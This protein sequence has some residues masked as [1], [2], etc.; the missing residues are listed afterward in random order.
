MP[1]RSD[2]PPTVHPRRSWRFLL[3]LGTVLAVASLLAAR[4]W[5]LLQPESTELRIAVNPW[6]GY[7]FAFLAEE[8]G[9]FR[10]EGVRVRLL[11]LSSLADA[12]RAFERGQAD[13]FFGTVVELVY[14]QEYSLRKPVPVMAVNVSEGAD[15]ILARPDIGSVADLRGRRVGVENGSLTVYV[16]ARALERH[17]LEWSDIEA[18]H[19]PTI[20][21]AAL[22]ALGKID[23]AVTYPPMSHEIENTGESRRVFTSAEIPGEVVDLFA[24]CRVVERERSRD[25]QAFCRAFFRAQQFAAEHPETAFRMMAARQNV[26]VEEFSQ[27]MTDG[28]RI[29]GRSDQAAYFGHAGTANA[30]VERVRSIM[31]RADAPQPGVML[32]VEPI[33]ERAD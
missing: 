1:T 16:L 27:S 3:A 10:E 24:M 2:I 14:A 32:V 22:F 26:S 28:I 4:S 21:A 25:V 20:Q 11:E 12:R 19:V 17:G 33:P 5:Q 30:I 29:L 23:A 7:E 18:V 13:G 31:V 8:L 15:L 6:P 9:Y